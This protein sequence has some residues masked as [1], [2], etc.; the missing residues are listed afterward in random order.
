MPPN[1]HLTI[2]PPQEISL[3]VS[4]HS[5]TLAKLFTVMM[6]NKDKQR[7]FLKGDHYTYLR[8]KKTQHNTGSTQKHSQGHRFAGKCWPRAWL[9]P[10]QSIAAQS[11]PQHE[12]AHGPVEQKGPFHRTP[13]WHLISF[14]FFG[15]QYKWHLL[16]CADVK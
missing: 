13:Q 2:I 12:G 6:K 4:T 5:S 8:G 15:W 16:A 10:F 3:P 14:L 9:A 11:H 1:R 7:T